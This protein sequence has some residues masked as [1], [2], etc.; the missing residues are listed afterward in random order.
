MSESDTG[1]E[2]DPV[3]VCSRAFNAALEAAGENC[4]TNEARV[5]NMASLVG[6]DVEEDFDVEHHAS[7]TVTEADGLEATRE[8]VLAMAVKKAEAG[9]TPGDALDAAW[10][11]LD[12]QPIE[13]DDDEEGEADE[14]GLEVEVES[15]EAGDEDAEEADEAEAETDGDED[16]EEEEEVDLDEL[17]DDGEGDDD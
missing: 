3:D 15:D 14:E 1:E 13:T 11:D 9:K 16:A 12:V 6:L 8:K 7:K 17:L 4:G 10:A 5:V 2:N